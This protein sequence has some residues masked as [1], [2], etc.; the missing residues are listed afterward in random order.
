MSFFFFFLSQNLVYDPILYLAVSSS[1]F[2]W[3]KRGIRRR[4]KVSQVKCERQDL[5]GFTFMQIPFGLVWLTPIPATI[6]C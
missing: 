3:L 1:L 6:M 5:E 2:L 4:K